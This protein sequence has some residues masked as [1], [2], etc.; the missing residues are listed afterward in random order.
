M[1]VNI[2][3]HLLEQNI[4]LKSYSKDNENGYEDHGSLG[5][6]TGSDWLEKGQSK[7]K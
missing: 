3:K 7:K 5:Q 2:T 6:E 1:A 4:L